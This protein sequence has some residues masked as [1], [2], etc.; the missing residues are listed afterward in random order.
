MDRGCT[1]GEKGVIQYYVL[2]TYHT[3]ILYNTQYI[4]ES[5]CIVVC[6]AIY[7]LFTPQSRLSTILPFTVYL[8]NLMA[9]TLHLTFTLSKPHEP[10]LFT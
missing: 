5:A 9:S 10:T 7:L 1:R 6:Y 2:H 3:I 4:A 8:S